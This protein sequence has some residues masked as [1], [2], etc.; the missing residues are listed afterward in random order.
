MKDRLFYERG[1]ALIIIALAA[2]GLFAVVG[3]AIDGSAKF[4]DQRRAQ[5]AADTT[6]MAAAL[7]KVTGLKNG[8]SNTPADCPPASGTPSTVCAALLNAGYVRATSNGYDGN[9]VTN[10][11]EIYS[12]P[13]SGPYFGN[14][15]YVQVIITSWVKTTFA[16]V[17]GITQTQNIVQATAYL[18]TGDSLTDGAMI[19]AYDPD[20]NCSTS[21]TG[22]YSVSVSGSSTVNLNKGGIFV[23]SRASCGFVIPNCA[24]LN[25]YDGTIYSAGNNIDLGSCTFD[26]T[27]TPLPDQTQDFKTIPDDVIWPGEPAECS[28]TPAAAVKLGEITVGTK[29]VEEWLI[30]PGYYESFPQ[31]A[32][33]AN[34]SNIYMKSG[35]Y[36]IDPGGPSWNGDLSWSPVDA[37]LLNGSTESD[38]TKSNYNK[39]NA[40]NPD[41]VTLFI[42]K[43]GGFSI[44]SNNPTYLDA[45]TSGKY[46]GYLIVLEGDQYSIES[47]NITAGSQ[48]YINGLIFAPYCDTTINGGSAPT[49]EINAQLVVWEIKINGTTTINFTYDPDN[50]VVYKSR[51]GLV[52]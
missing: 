43:G 10:T 49:A 3:L 23:N 21:G 7:A 40:Y 16:K 38:P 1:Q 29:I 22:G 26:P 39:Y 45:S 47:C 28:Q 25:I 52:R 48:L 50:Q 30:S 41:G 13:I 15:N 18:K 2:V 42:K 27:F 4:A 8:D 11:V 46:Q 17:I 51:I 12:P 5:N 37:S 6:A 20:P 14:E 19:V 33:V 24:D 44:N 9:L 34:K 32:L 35:V 36:C 31:A